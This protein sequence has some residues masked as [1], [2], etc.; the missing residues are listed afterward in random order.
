MRQLKALLRPLGVPL[1]A[2][3]FVVAASTA[4]APSQADEAWEWDPTRGYHEEEWYDPSDW[5]DDDTGIDYEDDYYGTYWDDWRYDYTGYDYDPYDAD[6]YDG[7]YVDEYD[8][9]GYDDYDYGYDYYTG[10]W[11]DDEPDFDNWYE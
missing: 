2:L 3:S 6:V 1:L 7:T 11:Y 10:D 9:Y 4:P 5:F 8:D